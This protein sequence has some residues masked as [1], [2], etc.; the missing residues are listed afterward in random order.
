[1]LMV[2]NDFLYQ[3]NADAEFKGM[4]DLM[5]YYN[6]KHP[7]LKF[8]VK[9]SNLNEYMND[10]KNEI[11]SGEVHPFRGDYFPFIN[12]KGTPFTGFYSS[13][14]NFKYFVRKNSEFN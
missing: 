3:N 1:M 5:N 10:F 11:K 9:I 2:G 4:E 13:R 14:P 6:V 12:G 8:R 7:E